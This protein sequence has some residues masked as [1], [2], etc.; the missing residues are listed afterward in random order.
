GRAAATTLICVTLEAAA[1]ALPRPGERFPRVTAEDLTGQT[2]STDEL[3][4]QRALVV[5]I[6]DREAVNAARGWYMAADAQ[7]AATVVP[8]SLVSLHLPFFITT[9]HAP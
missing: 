1:H 7:V 4:G 6:T 2:R 9:S 5:A 3:V 8:Q